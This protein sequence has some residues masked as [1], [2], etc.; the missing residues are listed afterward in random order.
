MCVR[1]IHVANKTPS[2]H[3]LTQAYIGVGLSRRR[4]FDD[5]KSS[6][7]DGAEN[8]AEVLRAYYGE[9]SSSS[10]TSP[11]RVTHL[12]RRESIRFDTSVN[13]ALDRIFALIVDTDQSGTV[14]LVEYSRIFELLYKLLWGDEARDYKSTRKQVRKEFFVDA[15]GA[16]VLDKLHFK[17]AWFQLTATWAKVCPQITCSTPQIF[18]LYMLL[19]CTHTLLYTL[20]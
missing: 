18:I 9:Q 15:G 2:Q 6:K 4:S 16:Q 12:L 5:F 19:Y 14:D 17:Q 13:D 11:K 8:L 1:A 7:H 20:L 3:L 10:S